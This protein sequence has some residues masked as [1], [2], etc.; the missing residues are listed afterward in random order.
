MD[1]PLSTLVFRHQ[2]TGQ[3]PADMT[4]R[5]ANEQQTILPIIHIQRQ[6]F[7]RAGV[8]RLDEHIKHL[9][10]LELEEREIVV[11]HPDRGVTRVHDAARVL[12]ALL[13]P[14]HAPHRLLP[15]HRRRRQR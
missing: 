9:P 7:M 10:N 4:H 11:R 13:R 1:P 12:C 6:I 2:E 15:T 5:I 3:R 14:V 8:P